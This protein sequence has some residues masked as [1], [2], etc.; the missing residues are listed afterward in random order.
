MEHEHPS[1]SVAI[2]GAGIAGLSA[3]RHLH[4]AGCTVHVFEKARG[5]GGR[6][7]TRRTNGYEFDHGAQ[8]FT[9]RHEWFREAVDRWRERGLVEIWPRRVVHVTSG[10]VRI[11]AEGDE[12]F[13]AVP[14]MNALCSDLSASLEVTLDS[15][16]SRIT[17]AGGT[18][19]LSSDDGRE[20]GRFDRVVV[21]TPPAQAAPLL[22]DA[23]ELAQQVAAADMQPCWAV[24]AVFERGLDS[25]W[26]AAFVSESPLSWVARN[27]SKPG[28]REDESWVLHASAEWS[29]AHIEADPSKVRDELIAA[30]SEALG[31]RRPQTISTSVHR[32]RYAKTRTPLASECLHDPERG[33]GVCGD[34][35]RG[36]RVED[37]FVSGLSLAKRI[38]GA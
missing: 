14:R 15:L 29:A 35:C 21:T 4:S 24:M 25:E 33:I 19:T 23:P 10:S 37:A 7:S 17:L 11:D 30:F 8:Y 9:V 6:M 13:V 2:V 12:R 38:A 34:W 20:L 36:D 3:A 16:V 31:T 28:R 22:A 27:A 18:W 1:T 32:W 5:P 26:D